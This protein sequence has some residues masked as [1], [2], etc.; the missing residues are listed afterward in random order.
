MYLAFP[1]DE[2][3]KAR[4]DSVCKSLGNTLEELF[5]TKRWNMHGGI[6]IDE[7]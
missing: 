4:L 1:V 7:K 5:D 3:V 6:F 2:K